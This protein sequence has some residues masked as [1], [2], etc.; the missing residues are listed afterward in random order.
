MEYSNIYRPWYDEIT[1]RKMNCEDLPAVMEY[2][3]RAVRFMND[4]GIRMW[5]DLYPTDTDLKADLARDDIWIA[6]HKGKPVATAV[7]NRNR[8][9]QYDEVKWDY[10]EESY[11]VIHRMCID[12]DYT[13]WGLGSYMLYHC[14]RMI[15]ENG[16]EHVRLDTFHGNYPALKLYDTFGY[17]VNG[18]AYYR[19]GFI[20]MLEK[21]LNTNRPKAG[22]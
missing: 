15:A 5:D 8:D 4:R 20:L 1:I 19:K 21:A 9:E 3:K 2:Y 6:V 11:M 22:D 7:L 13:G 12:P 17:K 10:P 18:G 14:E 16:F